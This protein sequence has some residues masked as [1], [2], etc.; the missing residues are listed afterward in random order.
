M[1]CGVNKG[2]GSGKANYGLWEKCKKE[3]IHYK[4]GPVDPLLKG[5][6]DKNLEAKM[7]PQTKSE[8]VAENNTF[9]TLEKTSD[10]YQQNSDEF[11]RNIR[12]KEDK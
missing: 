4:G 3:S 5:I 10:T 7:M 12:A 1:N 2:W 8:K 9:A 11:M 6:K